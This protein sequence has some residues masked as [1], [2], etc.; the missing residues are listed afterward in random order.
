[1]FHGAKSCLS[2]DVF[3]G[4]VGK[5]GDKGVG[6]TVV[7]CTKPVFF[8]QISRSKILAFLFLFDCLFVVVVFIKG[9]PG[10]SGER[11]D[12]GKPGRAVSNTDFPTIKAQFFSYI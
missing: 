6:G 4:F 8:V 3:Q 1:M 7:S 11:G 5:F 2:F 12:Q 9:A 10:I